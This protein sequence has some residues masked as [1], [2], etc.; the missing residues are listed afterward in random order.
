MHM[1]VSNFKQNRIG[2]NE[3]TEPIYAYIPFCNLVQKGNIIHLYSTY[4]V[5][6][7]TDAQYATGV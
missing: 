6:L 4:A 2:V 1:Y 5:K 3:Q 7:P